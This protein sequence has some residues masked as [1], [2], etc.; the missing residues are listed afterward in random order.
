M[1]S[2]P[3]TG[4]IYLACQE[5]RFLIKMHFMDVEFHYFEVGRV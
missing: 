2:Q 3:R 5:S 1:V 4:L